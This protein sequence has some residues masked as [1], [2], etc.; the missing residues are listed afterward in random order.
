MTPRRLEPED[1]GLVA[2][3]ELVRE[4]FRF[5][6]GVVDP[7]SSIHRLD[8]PGMVRAAAEGEVWVIG[9][10]P[11]ACVTLTPGDGHLYL[12][13]LAV[14]EAAR[15]RG[16]ARG[17]VELACTRA[18]DLGLSEVRLQTR[19]ELTGNQAAFRALGFREVGRSAHPGYDRPTSIT[20]ARA[21]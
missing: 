15:G 3:L 14:A 20:Y 4:N 12:G 13:K 9:D 5:M 7:P 21:V 6:D 17:L 19:V 11:L 1:P 2:A 18:R 16:L 10:P 8:L